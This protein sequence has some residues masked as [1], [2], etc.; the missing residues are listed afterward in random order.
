MNKVYL[1]LISKH[2][3]LKNEPAEDKII[4]LK[5]YEFFSHRTSADINDLY[6]SIRKIRRDWISLDVTT[7]SGNIYATISFLS[8]FEGENK[9][10]IPAEIISIVENFLEHD[11]LLNLFYPNDNAGFIE[12]TEE[13]EEEAEGILLQIEEHSAINE[14]EFIRELKKQNIKFEVITSNFL[15][16]DVGAS[17]FVAGA[18]VYILNAAAGG[19]IWDIMK[20]GLIKANPFSQ[21]L[22]DER[23][24]DNINYNKLLKDVSQRSKIKTK[25]LILVNMCKKDSEVMF[26][27]KANNS[28]ITVICNEK[29]IIQDFNLEKID[30]YKQ[31][32]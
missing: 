15:S 14:L 28:I 32:V 26:E 20:P 7:N 8:A 24:L 6:S 17:S 31:S 23:K 4:V 16:T 29:Y 2:T 12:E 3:N 10:T 19:I 25:D 11:L 5:E 18:I 9:T 22:L 1:K 30:I 27:F 13:T 21:K